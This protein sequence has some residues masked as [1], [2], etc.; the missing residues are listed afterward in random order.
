MLRDQ[1]IRRGGLWPQSGGNHAAADY[2]RLHPRRNGQAV[3]RVTARHGPAYGGWVPAGSGVGVG[4]GLDVGRGTG[5][6]LDVKRLTLMSERCYHGM[7][8]R[9]MLAL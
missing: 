9:S 5:Q 2:R 6:K 7:E 8:Y 1:D 3:A 4:V